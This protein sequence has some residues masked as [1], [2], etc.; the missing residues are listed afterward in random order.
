MGP[1]SHLPRLR[2][3][4]SHAPPH[5]NAAEHPAL[6]SSSSFRKRASSAQPSRPCSSF[7]AA[8]RFFAGEQPSS[9][10]SSF[11]LLR[12][13]SHTSATASMCLHVTEK[14]FSRQAT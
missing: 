13:I 9:T 3:Q 11:Q 6:V 8:I 14:L 12:F 5:G 1:H 4:A 2:L 7:T 10:S